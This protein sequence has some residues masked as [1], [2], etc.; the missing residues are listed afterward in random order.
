[1]EQRK[2]IKLGNSSFAIALPKN[3]VEKS[4]L[5]KGDRIFLEQ[6]VNGEIIVSSEFK[7]PGSEKEI[8][9]NIESKTKEEIKREFTSNYIKGGSVFIFKGKVNDEISKYIKEMVKE[10]LSCEIIEKKNEEIIVKDLF[11]IVELNVINSIKRMDNNIRELFDIIIKGIKEGKITKNYVEEIKKI[12]FDVNKFYFL[13][14]RIMMMGFSNPSFIAKIKLTP[15]ELFNS[16][17]LTFYL[18]QIGDDLKSITKKIGVER[19]NNKLREILVQIL[20]SL[21]KKYQSSLKIFYDNKSEEA[22]KLMGDKKI[23]QISESLYKTSWKL[24][25]HINE[26]VIRIDRAIYQIIKIIS[27]MKDENGRKTA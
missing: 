5:I 23:I 3:W 16:W 15:L 8:V 25:R 6:N 11:N 26:S 19:F 18:E 7:K 4:G 21:Q 24:Y 27:Y 10:Y 20:D 2:L 13:N 12:D 9:L 14:S 1:M 17:W 22:Y